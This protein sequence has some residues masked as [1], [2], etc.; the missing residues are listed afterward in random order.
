MATNTNIKYTPYEGEKYKIELVAER[1][2]TLLKTLDTTNGN[3]KT[4]EEL[5][6]IIETIKDWDDSD[7][8]LGVKEQLL[9][10]YNSMLSEDEFN[11]L[12]LSKIDE[13]I[14][15]VNE[16]VDTLETQMGD[17]SGGLENILT[18]TDEIIELQNLY[19]AGAAVDGDGS[20]ANITGDAYN[21]IIA[22]LNNKAD[23]THTHTASEVG[24]GNVPNVATNDQTPTYSDTSTLTTLSSGEKLNVALQKIKCAISNL[25]N[26]LN[27]KS[28]PHG[29]TA[30]QVGAAPE[31]HSHSAVKTVQALNTDWALENGMYKQTV[32]CDGL[33]STD[34]PI[35]DIVTGDSLDDNKLF[36]EAWS[37]VVRAVANDGN[38]T[39]YADST[40][41]VSF[42]FNIKVVR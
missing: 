7:D 20:D 26:H 39:L 27:N 14:A 18:Q 36:I 21:R 6:A 24:L 25:I 33:L 4:L 35:L 13:N 3:N 22:I 8:S 17:V 11:K 38:I 42:S 10:I 16:R 29:V 15:D 12:Y 5:N 1:I 37:H 40:P 32:E 23:E 2:N 28:N 31:Q 19:I 41:D 30:T 9:N 34:T